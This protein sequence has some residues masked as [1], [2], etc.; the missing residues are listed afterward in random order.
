MQSKSEQEIVFTRLLRLLC[1][2]FLVRV[3]PLTLGNLLF[4]AT[5]VCKI[6]SIDSSAER[7]C[8]VVQLVH[9]FAELKYQ[10]TF[11]VVI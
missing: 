3:M 4:R 10:N 5:L 2:L 11:L 1:S 6:A 7:L 9:C 8:D